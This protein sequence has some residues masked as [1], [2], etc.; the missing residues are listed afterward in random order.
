M[1]AERFAVPILSVSR[2]Q[3][4]QFQPWVTDQFHFDLATLFGRYR[5]KDL[6]NR[7]Q[8]LADEEHGTTKALSQA[9]FIK[10]FGRPPWISLS[11]TFAAF[12][13]PYEASAP[14][15]NDYAPISFILRKVHGGEPV[16]PSNLSSGERV[17]LQFAVSSYQHDDGLT[18]ITRPNLL[19][20]DELGAPL[21]PEMVHRLA[22]SNQRRLGGRTEGAVHP[23]YTLPDH[24]GSRA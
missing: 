20:L 15:L 16:H 17:L 12:G 21:H 19:L 7:L 1:V 4:S 3:L 13:L 18:N 8:R 14:E 2:K 9:A 23:D 5:D 10:A 6:R 22:W 24:C 11:E